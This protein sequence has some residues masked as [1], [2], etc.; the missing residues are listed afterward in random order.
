ML[1]VFAPLYINHHHEELYGS[2]VVLLPESNC[3]VFR[4]ACFE[5][6]ASPGKLTYSGRDWLTGS[7]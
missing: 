4:N 3:S 7:E 5:L 6:E 1:S 2:R